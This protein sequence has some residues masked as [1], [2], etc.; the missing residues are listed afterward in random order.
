MKTVRVNAASPYDALIG[1]GLMKEAGETVAQYIRPC[2]AALVSDDQ[3][4]ALYGNTVVESL[5]QAGFSVVSFIFPHGEGS[6]CLETLSGLLSFMAGEELTRSDIVV[7]LGGGVTG[8]MAGFAAAV[9]LRGIRC[10]QMPTTL[11]AA[12][13]A[14][15]GGK[16]AV[17]LPEGK[18]L[19]GVF[20]QPSLVLCD[21]DSF[22]TLP[23]QTFADGVAESLK[24]GIICDRALFDDM[25][26]GVNPRDAAGIVERCI[27]IKAA[28]VA[29]D[30]R[31]RGSRQ[32]LNFGHTYGHAVEAASGFTI[33]HGHAVAMGM[34]AMTRAAEA[35]GVCGQGSA[36]RVQEALLACDL[37]ICAPYSPEAL[38][39]AALHDK[40]RQGDTVT[41]VLPASIG[42]CILYPAPVNALSDI[43]RM[44]GEP[45]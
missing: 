39:A 33:S 8:D 44:G 6:K 3:V 15:V 24:H 21:C 23:P 25:A 14:S 38:A 4:F 34:A 32:L 27:V 43:F 12:V 22:D 35:M 10:V 37:P 28:L 19:A 31:D 45:V 5:V 7:A 20:W 30:E 13:D 40:K 29:E 17:N 11:L 36:R 26:G 41:L 42:R 2:K 9:Y 18:N 16:T 1:H